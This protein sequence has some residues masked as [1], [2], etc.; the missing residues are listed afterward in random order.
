MEGY[1]Q[2]FEKQVLIEAMK[3][4]Y[5]YG[6]PIS[7]VRSVYAGLRKVAQQNS[8]Q[9]PASLHLRINDIIKTLSNGYESG[10]G[11]I[12]ECEGID[13][14]CFDVMYSKQVARNLYAEK[15]IQLIMQNPSVKHPKMYVT[16]LEGRQD[17]ESLQAEQ[18]DESCQP[19]QASAVSDE[20]AVYDYVLKSELKQKIKA[21]TDNDF[22][23]CSSREDMV[24]LFN[25]ML[26]ECSVQKIKA[27][28]GE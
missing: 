25:S 9:L 19:G 7:A 17:A 16:L 1:D 15:L 24:R 26:E 28:G 5:N 3:K 14:A 22:R 12:M 11:F 13:S 27:F 8:L 2:S 20:T 4:A 23:L 21:V 6:L 18:A 10:N